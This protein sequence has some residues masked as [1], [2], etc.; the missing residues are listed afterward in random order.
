MIGEHDNSVSPAFAQTY[1]DQEGTEF[2]V[3][4]MDGDHVPMLSRPEAVV[5]VIRR[6]AEGDVESG[7]RAKTD[8]L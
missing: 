2:E 8:E 7:G 5:D 3:E 4:I 1:I 6:F